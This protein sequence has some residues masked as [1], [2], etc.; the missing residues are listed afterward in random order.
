M[1]VALRGQF[2]EL[3]GFMRRLQKFNDT[4]RRIA[5]ELAPKT[6]ALV[7]ESFTAQASPEGVSWPAT[8]SGEPAFGGGDALGYVLSRVSGKS[9]IRTTVLFPLHFH[10]DGTHRIGRKRGRA[11]ASKIVGGYARAVLA[12]HG[13]KGSAPRQRKGESDEAFHRRVEAFARAKQVR[14]EAKLSARKHAASAIAEARVAG[15]WHD[16]PRPMIPDE[17]DPIPSRW[18]ETITETARP[19]L[20]E[21]G[22]T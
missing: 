22:A 14:Q 20:A 15:G 2:D 19:I 16:P 12:Q 8:K 3:S 18:V 5:V 13:L 6:A 17:G 7:G 9:S 10:Q 21:I 11:L 1:I 4:S